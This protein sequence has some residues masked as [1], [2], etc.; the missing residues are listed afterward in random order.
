MTFSGLAIYEA[1]DAQMIPHLS[2]NTSVQILTSEIEM[3]PEGYVA[4][5]MKKIVESD[6]AGPTKIMSGKAFRK[7]L[8][9]L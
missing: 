2:S 9:T 6:K 7:W 5:T 3:T 4:S 1:T 8:D